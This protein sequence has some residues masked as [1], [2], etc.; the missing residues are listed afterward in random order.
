MSARGAIWVDAAVDELVLGAQHDAVPRARRFVVESL[1]G[2]PDSQREDAELVVAELVTNALL[3]GAPPITLRVHRNGEIVRLDVE[4]QGRRRPVLV[5]NRDD[6][7]TGRGLSLVGCLARAWG[8]EPLGNGS[9]VVWAELSPT[10]NAATDAE[11]DAALDIDDLLASWADLGE[12]AEPTFSVSLGSVP[13]ALLLEAK[14]QLD[15]LVREFTLAGSRADEGSG[16]PLSAELA[17]LM[18]TVVHG[19]ADARAQIKQQ[20]LAAAAR[21]ERHAEL[22]LTLP[23]SAADAGERYLAALD[24]A[25]SYA[26][27]ARLLTLETPPAHRVFRDWYVRALVAELRRVAAGAERADQMTFEERLA[28]EV[29]ELWPLREVSERLR[30]LQQV[31]AALTGTNSV[32]DVVTLVC[33]R[34]HDVLGATSARIY[35]LTPERTLRSAAAVVNDAQLAHIYEEF[36]V[37]A[38]LPGGEALR[39]GKPVVLRSQQD[40]A[41]RFPELAA[42]YQAEDRTLLVAP[43]TVAERQLGVLSLT[44]HGR[45][46]TDEQTQLAFLT[47]LA[48]VTA[49]ALERTAASAAA[50]QASDRLAFLAEASVLLSSTLDY[51][52]VLEAVAALVVPRLADWCVIQLLEDG[53]LNTVAL[54]HVDPKKVEWA[55]A[56]SARYPNDMDADTGAPQVIRTGRSELY[57]FIPP[58]LIEAGA[59]DEEHLR[60]IREFGLSSCL[61]VPLA[62]RGG[63]IGALT[64]IYAESGRRYDEGDVAFAEDVA[65]R[66]ALAVETAHAFHEQS[67]RL[68]SVTR[69]A[70]AAQ[71]AILATLPP[72]IG[73]VALSARYVSAAADA[74]VGGDLY[75]VVAR[76]GAVRLLV[77]D[78]RGKGLDAVRHATVVLGEFRAAAADVDDLV[79]VATQIDRRLRPY[80]DD[81]DFVTAVLAEVTD[82]GELTVV[83]CGHPAPLVARHGRVEELA[84]APTLPLGLGAAPVPV[85][86]QLEVGDRLLLYTDGII[87][88]RD[89]QQQFVDLR[90]VVATLAGGRLDEVLDRVL[91]ALRRSVGAALGDDLAL[92]V[93]EYRGPH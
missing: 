46:H 71:H 19:F 70:E 35:L 77:G 65:R 26:R 21:G 59:A 54:S 1:R 27:S 39:T 41:A 58:E 31:T 29:T 20:A 9:K 86:D 85:R 81:E 49:Q 4:D 2:I 28:D 93:A 79:D 69:V 18:Q 15:N 78:V 62:G 34:A 47:T 6:A 44:F 11:L 48:D 92:V 64:L 80:L 38:P 75:E 72:R 90:E 7:M 50:G 66:A 25:D 23:L 83:N 53:A 82:A 89:A 51:R 17:E 87:E 74:L 68:A 10:S 45:G 60:L 12:S 55:L 22:R 30:L 24:E 14:A 56:V 73:A 67:G 43:L 52:A 40:I 91:V 57:P 33:N 63:I 37:D 88:A 3:H 13:T 61:V 36:D 42:T 84:T 8:V 76:D 32:E 16:A 5:R